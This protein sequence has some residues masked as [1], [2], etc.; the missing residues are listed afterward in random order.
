LAEL[1]FFNNRVFHHLPSCKHLE[2]QENLTGDA[3]AHQCATQ[4]E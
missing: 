2:Q 4:K 3:L 1:F